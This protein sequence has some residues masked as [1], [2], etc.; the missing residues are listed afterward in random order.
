MRLQKA[1]VF[2]MSVVILAALGVSLVMFRT[3]E[4]VKAATPGAAIPA[5]PTCFPS[6]QPFARFLSLAGSSLFTFAGGSTTIGIRVNGIANPAT[7]VVGVFDGDNAGL[8]DQDSANAGV[9]VTFELFADANNDGTPD[10]AVPVDVLPTAAMLDNNWQ[11]FTVNHFPSARLG[12]AG[13]DYVYLLKA[14][15]TT[16]IG[17]VQNDFKIGVDSAQSSLFITPQVLSLQAFQNQ[18]AEFLILH[19]TAQPHCNPGETIPCAPSNYDGTWSFSFLVNQTQQSINV[20]DGDFDIGE[21]APDS[22]G[23]LIQSDVDTDD[24]TTPNV[25]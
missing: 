24:P 8:W 7:F 14:T 1:L 16:A 22:P 18:L 20:W 4:T 11:Y 9:P 19:P 17:M 3:Q 6:C 2:R 23:R 5:N 10:S 15:L 21:N 25:R 13:T 12:G